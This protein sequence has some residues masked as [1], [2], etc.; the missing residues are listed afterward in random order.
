MFSEVF[1]NIFAFLPSNGGSNCFLLKGQ[2][3]IALIDSSSR[4][5]ASAL[6][7]SLKGIGVKPGEVTL[8]IHTHGH[9]D[10]FGCDGLFS[11]A[12]IAM[13]EKDGKKINAGLE[14]FACLHFFPGTELPKVSFFLKAGQ[15]LDLGGMKLKVIHC[16]GHTSGSICLLLEP[17]KILFSG[18]CLFV[19]GFGRADLASGNAQNLVESLKKL[20][21]TPFKALFPGHGPVLLGD[22]K[23]ALL[24]LKK[25]VEMA[26]NTFL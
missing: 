12:K 10:H 15:S 20:Q 9:A 26:T 7:S 16:P 3:E 11:N 17:G 13:H 21:K 22:E 4:D 25:I 5:N 14:E 8:L 6:I 19:E 23:N 1:P 24:H 2:K 18:D